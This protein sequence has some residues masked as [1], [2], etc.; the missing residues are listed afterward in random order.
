[1]SGG[2]LSGSYNDSL[3]A[4]S[5]DDQ[6]MR[7]IC[8]QEMKGHII[9]FLQTQAAKTGGNVRVFDGAGAGCSQQYDGSYNRTPGPNRHIAWRNGSSAAMSH[10]AVSVTSG[11]LPTPLS[12]PHAPPA[13]RSSSQG[14]AIPETEA[15]QPDGSWNSSLSFASGSRCSPPQPAVAAPNGADSSG[16]VARVA[17]RLEQ[18]EDD[19]SQRLF[20]VN[21]S[22]HRSSPAADANASENV[23][24]SA[25]AAPLGCANDSGDL[26]HLHPAASSPGLSNGDSAQHSHRYGGFPFRYD[27]LEQHPLYVK[28]Q[29]RAMSAGKERFGIVDAAAGMLAKPARH[30]INP[31]RTSSGSGSGTERSARSPSPH[32]APFQDPSARRTPANGS[33]AKAVNARFSLLDDD[34][35]SPVPGGP[36]SSFATG[37]GNASS[38]AQRPAAVTGASPSIASSSLPPPGDIG[39]G[40][41]F[42]H[43]VERL[44]GGGQRSGGAGSGSSLAWVAA[45]GNASWSASGGGGDRPT[46]NGHSAD[47]ARGYPGYPESVPQRVASPASTTSL[48]GDRELHRL[49]GLRTA[50]ALLSGEPLLLLPGGADSASPSPYATR[51]LEAGARP[52]D[53]PGSSVD[54]ASSSHSSTPWADALSTGYG[55]GGSGSVLGT[56]ASAASS[57]PGTVGREKPPVVGLRTL[58][59]ED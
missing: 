8:S 24:K 4:F 42:N 7:L 27:T 58:V 12:S 51:L 44:S 22:R 50:H 41:G 55:T 9:R 39:G 11:R 25:S 3:P 26:V 14:Y 19:P 35:P 57:S 59:F 31:L 29:G 38:P 16:A 56:P 53:T 20:L 32:V 36:I 6:E 46:A 23:P 43:V 1:M 45:Q 5:D 33:S 15:E 13:F 54:R 18:P 2:L 37:A 52:S 21:G 28:S 47:A 48:G 10:S 49:S 34:D 30:G 40:S 17:R